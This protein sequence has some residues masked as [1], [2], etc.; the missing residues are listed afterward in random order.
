[1]ALN[2]FLKFTLNLILKM[3]SFSRFKIAVSL[4]FELVI[5]YSLN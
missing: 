4:E 2:I 5:N 3:K 1:M